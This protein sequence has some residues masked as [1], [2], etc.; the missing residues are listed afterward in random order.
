M[1]RRVKGG[2]R[3]AGELYF[4]KLSLEK[5]NNLSLQS[6]MFLNRGVHM[7]FKS[8][9]D[10]NNM[11]DF[12]S[13][14][15]A[16]LIESE[17][18]SSLASTDENEESDSN[19]S[20]DSSHRESNNEKKG[21]V[22]SDSENDDS[23][24]ESH[25]E[26]I[27]AEGGT[28]GI[29]GKLRDEERK[30]GSDQLDEES[31]SSEPSKS[32]SQQNTPSVI[33][34]E[35][36]SIQ[37]KG[38][39]ETSDSHCDH[40]DDN[41]STPSPPIQESTDVYTAEASDVSNTQRSDLTNSADLVI[42]SKTDNK[43]EVDVSIEG[44]EKQDTT[45]EI[46]IK[47]DI[48]ITSM[49]SVVE[50]DECSQNNPTFA[51]CDTDTIAKIDNIHELEVNATIENDEKEHSKKQ[52][53]LKSDASKTS[54]E[55]SQ[56]TSDIE[57]L[58]RSP[59]NPTLREGETS[60]A[61]LSSNANKETRSSSSANKEP[62]QAKMDT[63][64]LSHLRSVLFEALKTEMTED[65]S[66]I[67]DYTITMVE[68]G[69]SAIY[70]VD[71]LATLQME[72]CDEAM[73]SKLG[74]KVSSYCVE[75]NAEEQRSIKSE[76][77]GYVWSDSE[78]DSDDDSASSEPNRSYERP[79]TLSSNYDALEEFSPAFDH[80][81][82]SSYRSDDSS[83]ASYINEEVTESL[84]E[85]VK[86]N[87]SLLSKL[88]PDMEKKESSQVLHAEHDKKKARKGWNSSGLMQRYDPTAV[89]AKEFEVADPDNL[90]DESNQ[91]IVHPNNKDEDEE[92]EVP[93]KPLDLDENID[94]PE[95]DAAEDSSQKA[96]DNSGG[97]QSG[98][99]VNARET[100]TSKHELNTKETKEEKVIHSSKSSLTEQKSNG[101][102][103]AIATDVYEEKK[104]E[105]VFA[106]ERSGGGTADFK[107]NSIFGDT[108]DLD[109]TSNVSS[110]GNGG[111][112]FSFDTPI[113]SEQKTDADIEN[114]RHT[115]M[116]SF[117]KT[118]DSIREDPIGENIDIPQESQLPEPKKKSQDSGLEKRKGFHFPRKMLLGF[119][120]N[121]FSMNE[122]IQNVTSAIQGA[123]TESYEDDQ[124][125][126]HDERRTLTL[127]WKRK[128]KQSKERNRKKMKHR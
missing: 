109:T 10:V 57:E 26:E 13:S 75:D 106:Q 93:A 41:L 39:E 96:S 28:S 84:E 33:P 31:F 40:V 107:F 18:D 99:N 102:N 22:W 58:K 124:A 116:Q 49:E 119:E 36:I 72:I 51:T 94:E 89:S 111:F 125:Q 77:K 81:S 12:R 61:D 86:S 67:V 45:K 27:K 52:L 55:S 90:N 25:T 88:F 95:N 48:S 2:E 83:I 82:K 4:E 112:S 128:H 34:N 110:S 92:P 30:E 66:D 85:D 37:G 8:L 122:G 6:K 121:F 74:E 91:E 50:E 5:E 29:Q 65:A 68:N 17:N 3:S 126:W 21:Y 120:A 118:P 71:E 97:D 38:F 56:S 101:N 24:I 32:D 113:T 46:D 11:D 79:R 127:D 16:D 47:G 35:S 104:L 63:K 15:I 53:G 54:V 80:E 87:L 60:D 69:K 103:A 105:S 42:I 9:D 44:N 1:N 100:L 7:S 20:D 19:A 108:K 78:D 59:N 43:E 62:S 23:D 115:T 114:E 76:T 14:G 73:A 98:G 70:I 123:K 117:A 64:E